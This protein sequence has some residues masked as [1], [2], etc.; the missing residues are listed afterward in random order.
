MVTRLLNLCGLYLGP[1]E[2]LMPARADDNPVGYWENLRFVA[3]NDDLLTALGGSWNHP[4]DA[5]AEDWWKQP[6]FDAFRRRASALLSHFDAHPCWGWKDP[7]TCL[8]LPF[9]LSLVPDLRI[10]LCLRNPLEIALSLS[11]GDHERSLLPEDALPLW[12]TYHERLLRTVR[13]VPCVTTHYA[14]YFYD[15]RAE[16]ARVLTALGMTATEDAIRQATATIDPGLRHRIYAGSEIPSE[17]APPPLVQRYASLCE[18]AGMVFHHMQTD[19]AYR[20]TLLLEGHRKQ[21]TLLVSQAAQ[22]IRILKEQEALQATHQQLNQVIRHLRDEKAALA[23]SAERMEQRHATLEAEYAARVDATARLEAEKAALARRVEHLEHTRTQQETEKTALARRFEHLARDHAH[24]AAE[25][26]R[27]EASQTRLEQEKSALQT[28]RGRLHREQQARQRS[29]LARSMQTLQNA[30]QRGITRVLKRAV[31]GQGASS[32]LWIAL[33]HPAPDALCPASEPLHISGWAFSSAGT[34]DRVEAFLE[35]LKLGTLPHGLDRPDVGAAFPDVTDAGR[36]GYEQSFAVNDLE[37]GPYALVV[38]ITDTAGHSQSVQRRV[39]LG[40]PSAV[41][42]PA[43]AAL[44]T[45]GAEPENAPKKHLQIDHARWRE[46]HL[47][48]QGWMV[49]PHSRP[50]HTVRVWMDQQVVGT[51]RCNLSRPDISG[52]YPESIKPYCRGFALSEVRAP[53]APAVRKI[54]T[55]EVTDQQGDTLRREITLRHKKDDGGPAVAGIQRRFQTFVLAYKARTSRAPSVLDWNTNG[56]LAH[57]FP[58]CAFFTPPGPVASPSL[59]YADASI[60]VVLCPSTTPALLA[61]ARRVATGAVLVVKNH[62]VHTVW[63]AEHT[64]EEPTLEASLIIPVFNQVAYTRKCLDQLQRLLPD[65]VQAEVIVVDDAST[66]ETPAVLA[67]LARAWPLL[68]VHRNAGNLGFIHSCNRGAEAAS[69][70]FLVFLNNDTV[71]QPGWLVALLNTFRHYPEAGA[72]GGKLIY[73]DGTLQEAGGLIFSDGSG[74]NFGRNDPAPDH[75]LYNHVREVDYCSGAL[76]AT[77]RSL[78]MAVQGFDRRYAPA[79]YE[80]TDYCFRV[81][82]EGYKVYYQ[83]ESVVIHFE[84]ASSG[85]DVAAGIKRYQTINRQKFVARWRDALQ[86]QPPPPPGA[87][88]K[89]RYRLVVRDEREE[90]EPYAY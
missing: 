9:W 20:Q 32:P 42:S 90:G 50:P 77:R 78:F 5:A 53:D 55:L 33:D 82:Q 61:E 22:A 75:P 68:Q 80:D 45:N 65:T 40:T 11:R 39:V 16:L 83:P 56:A 17:A 48:V 6:S 3:L 15:S 71:P 8:T 28:E 57:H 51:A 12:E 44:P 70:P 36:S 59:P 74:W 64:A 54:V 34:L 79:Y 21:H 86:R 85:T 63:Q 37:P 30:R 67:D 72:V 89:T 52:R 58:A 14:S 62:R 4:P 10:V 24:Q 73:P 7:R 88:M 76:L 43:Q 35:R 18:Q 41:A 26:A 25:I 46:G 2:D 47:E 1:E 49:W 87:V 60:D 29:A 81:R 19:A 27:L 66:D 13:P 38:C 23:H 31:T 69:K 84:G